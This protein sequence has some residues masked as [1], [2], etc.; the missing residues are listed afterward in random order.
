[1]R[2]LN[3]IL[4]VF[5]LIGA[6]FQII[7]LVS[8]ELEG[9]TI[10]LSYFICL[11]TLFLLWKNRHRLEKFGR[12]N[13]KGAGWRFVLL[14]SLGA[15]WVE[16]IF[17]LVET[18]VGSVGVAAHPNIFID[19]LVTMPWYIS[20]VAVLWLIYKRFRY[21]WTTIALLG[22]IYEIGGDGIVGHL[23]QGN[24]ITL[25]H[26]FLLFFVYL[27]VFIVVYG[28]MVL[29]PVWAMNLPPLKKKK[30]IKSFFAILL[31][32]LPLIPY[33]LIMIILFSIMSGTG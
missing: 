15:L 25:E 14:G 28:P 7:L 32:L 3:I 4:I 16:F 9:I 8:G 17:W 29:A 31:P 23:L 10:S 19:W 18:I 11:I 26:L 13:E 12:P 30:P 22:G 2:G 24:A 20:M 5:L 27:G 21:K 33:Y 1:M 6:I